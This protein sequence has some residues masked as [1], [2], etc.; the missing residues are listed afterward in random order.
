MTNE[1]LFEQ[2][3]LNIIKYSTELLQDLKRNNLE[4]HPN[5]V[6]KTATITVIVCI[7]WVNFNYMKKDEITRLELAKK[8]PECV[9]TCKPTV[10][11]R[12]KYKLER[13][14]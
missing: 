3:L 4:I 2:D 11:L 9:Q 6:N 8:Y 13:L 14:K 5:D 10:C 7:V 1:E 12:Y